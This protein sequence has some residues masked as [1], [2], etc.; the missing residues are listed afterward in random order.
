MAWLRNDLKIRTVLDLRTPE[1]LASS[2]LG[3]VSSLR[4]THHSIPFTRSLDE[5]LELLNTL[6]GMGEFYLE[7]VSRKS[8]GDNLMEALNIIA[9]SESHPLAFHCSV[10]KDRT[11]VLAALLQGVL[12]VSD[13]DI[14]ADYALS[15]EPATRS[16]Q[17][18]MADPQTSGRLS[19]LPS[20]TAEARPE[21][22]QFFLSAL[23]KE[24]GSVRGYV[25]AQGEDAALFLQ[26]ENA[27]LE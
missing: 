15:H 2:G 13:D 19:S 24:Y 4:I 18:A 22:M 20:F 11:G 27:L 17:R 25:E 14:I 10:G 21:F 23:A 9:S 16:A 5:D 6:A 8:F 12:G 7:M 1:E 3:G 26:L